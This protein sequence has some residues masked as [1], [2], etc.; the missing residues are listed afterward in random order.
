LFV[1]AVPEM[2]FLVTGIDFV[3]SK[4]KKENVV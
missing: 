2:N 3:Q 1:Y 4:F